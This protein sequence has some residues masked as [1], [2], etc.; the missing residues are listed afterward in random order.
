MKVVKGSTPHALAEKQETDRSY[1][2]VTIYVQDEELSKED[3]G[4]KK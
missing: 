2:A 1:G 4:Q 3:A